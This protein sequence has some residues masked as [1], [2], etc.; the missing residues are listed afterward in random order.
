VPIARKVPAQWCS[1]PVGVAV[2]AG[3]VEPRLVALEVAG[4]P[5]EGPGIAALVAGLVAA[6]SELAG[7]PALGKVLQVVV[8]LAWKPA[9]LALGGS[10]DKAG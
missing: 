6:S 5:V 7:L 10:V 1:R 4:K 3:A 9:A 2:T 8:Q